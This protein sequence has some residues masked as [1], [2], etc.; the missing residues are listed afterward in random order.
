MTAFVEVLLGYDSFIKSPFNSN[1]FEF[2]YLEV[3]SVFTH[4]FL[5]GSDESKLGHTT[6]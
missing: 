3:A 5:S 6:G 1:L 4:V 2:Q